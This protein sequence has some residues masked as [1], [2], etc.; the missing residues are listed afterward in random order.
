MSSEKTTMSAPVHAVVTQLG[1]DSPESV[2]PYYES[3]EWQRDGISPE[4]L[5]AD[6][7]TMFSAIERVS[8]M[9][10]HSHFRSLHK[11]ADRW[12]IAHKS[13]DG[14]STGE[15]SDSDFMRL[16]DVWEEIAD[17][18]EVHESA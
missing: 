18:L 3:G 5:A 17:S 8:R 4:M 11:Y 16:L 6:C 14:V 1:M 13:W 10:M 12:G 2:A 15:I 9:M 7:V